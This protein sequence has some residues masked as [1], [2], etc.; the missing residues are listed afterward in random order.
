MDA[1]GVTDDASMV[2]D[3]IDSVSHN[4]NGLK[5]FPNPFE[6]SNQ[7]SAEDEKLAAGK[8]SKR[9]RIKKEELEK[10]KINE[11]INKN[12]ERQKRF[13]ADVAAKVREFLTSGGDPIEALS[14]LHAAMGG[15]PG[16]ISEA[17]LKDSKKSS[18]QNNQDNQAA[19]ENV[20]NTLRPIETA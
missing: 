6:P 12:T 15:V 10:Q 20:E 4:F 5:T 18:A 14:G 11:I 2:K 13:F 7:Q 17:A 3:S 19:Q 1:A 16:V 9:E 8:L